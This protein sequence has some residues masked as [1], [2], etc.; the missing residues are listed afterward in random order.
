MTRQPRPALLLTRPEA[1]SR[2]FAAELGARA[3]A[4]AATLRVVISPLMSPVLLDVPLPALLA[5]QAGTPSQPEPEVV[6]VFSSETGVAGFARLFPRRD[7][8]ALCVGE[9][10]AAAARAAGFHTTVAGPDAGG[11]LAALPDLVGDAHVVVVRGKDTACPMARH[12]SG[13]GIAATE[14]IVYDQRAQPPGTEALG[15]LAGSAPVVVPIFSPRSAAL[16]SDMAAAST[17]PLWIVAISEAARAGL[18]G[19]SP[20]RAIVSRTPDGEGML[21]ATAHMLGL[22]EQP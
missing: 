9:R 18:G 17:A 14:M 3:G 8:R 16:F 10:T 19:L 11:L 15:L 20:V 12:L 4:A 6:L 22:D 13:R 7:L 5:P 1:Q 21:T 2:R